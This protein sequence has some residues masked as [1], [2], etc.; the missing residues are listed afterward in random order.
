MP[1]RA[2]TSE[3][4]QQLQGLFEQVL[5][6]PP[7]RRAA[8]LAELAPDDPEIRTEVL[9]LLAAH[10]RAERAWPAPVSDAASGEPGAATD[11]WVGKRVGAYEIVRLV[12]VGGMGAVYEATRADD[13][14][15][16]R[17]AI[18][19][20]HQQAASPAAVRRFRAERQILATLSHPGIAAL[21][22]GGVTEE[23]HPF[24]V[25]EYV[26]GE[27]IT[28]WCDAHRLTVR[29]RLQLLQ[30]V[31]AAVQSAH[32]SLVVHRDLKPGNILVTAE[33][34]VV[35]LDFG[36]ARLLQGEAGTD[37]LPTTLTAVRSF[38][39]EYA[40]P[41][42]V[43]GEPTRTGVDLYALGVL[44]FELLTGTRPFDLRG[45][46]LSEV[47]RIVCETP[48]PAPS[49]R[50]D[51]AQAERLG[52]R[53]AARA[54][55]LVAGDL[56]AITQ[57]ALRKEPGRRYLSAGQMGR[58]LQQHLDGHP[59]SARPDGLGYRMRKLVGR[60]KLETAA[61]VLA[62]ASLA[63]G[64]VGV[65]VQAQ[66]AR[67]EAARAAQVTS[68]LTTTFG[69][70]NPASLGRD[71]TVREV[72]D[73]AAVR[74][75]TLAGTPAL[76]AEIRTVIGN[77]YMALGE[78]EAADHQFRRAIEADQRHAPGG[79]HETAIAYTRQSYA[80][81]YLGQYAAADS[82]F[83]LGSALIQRYPYTDPLEESRFLDQRGRILSRLGR[84]AEAEPLF[85]RALALNL[86]NAPTNDSLLASSYANL[87]FV[88]VELGRTAAAESLYAEGIAR[89]RRAFG[90]VHPDLADLLSPFASVLDR[91]GKF[92]QA[93]STYREVLDMRRALLG[94]EHPEYAWTMFNYAD[95][96]LA[97]ERYAEAAKWSRAVLALQGKTLPETHIAVSTA[98]AVL[99][100]AL[101]GMDSTA[102]GGRYL[103]TS[104]QLRRKTLPEGHWLIA[105]SES[106]LGEHLARIGRYA[107]AE[108][109]LT[110]SERKL[111]EARGEDA[112][113]VQDA[114][115]RRA[116]LYRLWGKTDSTDRR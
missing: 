62:A 46:S 51:A 92:A 73:S 78:F 13:Q 34:R 32:Q 104:L 86:R 66:R 20:L 69:S 98:M 85:Q 44:L 40:A 42:Q 35:L 10:E 59:V 33:G 70:A 109:L 74:A 1:E 16:K 27:P 91:A 50:I 38:T 79:D 49:T 81:E 29:E 39:P 4:L 53:S 68:F 116:T 89:A 112:P 110:V 31:A 107:E 113:V 6:V 100:R 97:Q 61:V 94:P 76:E 43:R 115:R 21:L 101:D 106:I 15:R 108:S 75:D 95:F 24:F 7:T 22:D 5:E 84:N 17:V 14:F 65:M 45:K 9:A 102:A 71:V 12:G 114:R 111:I 103:R 80:L 77:T 90:P 2:L 41:E 83:T 23:G 25:M 18:K 54:G 37:S 72:L 63:G 3:Y 93:D 67:Q 28:R 58:D 8:H 48:P 64:V 57:M 60:R 82:V 11:R 105:S 52:E 47:E 19:F 30:Q 87:G 99:G 56:D 96:L 26:D 55:A 36:I 88:N